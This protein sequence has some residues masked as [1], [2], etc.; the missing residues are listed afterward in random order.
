M[1]EGGSRGHVGHGHEDI[2]D[3]NDGRTMRKRARKVGGGVSNSL[4]PQTMQQLS[5]EVTGMFQDVGKSAWDKKQWMRNRM[6]QLE[7]QRISYHTQA[8]EL[9]KQSGVCKSASLSKGNV[10]IGRECGAH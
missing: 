6:K 4:S 2:E 8:F 1:G 9:E 7:E 3:E 5:A 10:E